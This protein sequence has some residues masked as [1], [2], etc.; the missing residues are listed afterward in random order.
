MIQDFNNLENTKIVGVIGHPIRQSLSPFMHNTA[1]EIAG[2]DY[3]YLPFDVPPS[4]LKD[5]LRGM[6]ALNFSGFN[7]TLPLKENIAD[8][9]NEISEEAAVIGAVNTIVNENGS[10]HGYNTDV[11]GVVETLNDVAEEINGSIVTVIGSGGAARSVIYALIRNYSPKLI[12]IVNRTAQKAES[13]TEYFIEKMLYEDFA[14]YELV[15]PDLVDVFKNSKLIVNTTSIGMF[16]DA[17]DSATEIID[18]FH[19]GQIV[20]DVI[21]NPLKTRLLSLAESKG[22]KTINGLKMFLHQGARAFELWTD[23]KMPVDEILPRLEKK[24]LEKQS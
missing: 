17:D 12:N 16:P 19:E 6:V 23:N 15:P 14:S 8:Y 1:F 21:Y 18:S 13:L 5:A 2:L 7:V 11:H 3:I 4:N 20:F 24:L 22:A 10:L 9:L